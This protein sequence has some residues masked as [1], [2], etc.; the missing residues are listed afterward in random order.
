MYDTFG[1]KQICIPVMDR[2]HSLVSKYPDD[3]FY[4][5]PVDLEMFRGHLVGHI[6]VIRVPHA[7]MIKNFDAGPLAI[8]R[9]AARLRASLIRGP[10]EPDTVSWFLN[11]IL[12][13]SCGIYDPW[14]DFE[15]RDKQETFLACGETD[16]DFGQ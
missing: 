3:H 4:G 13:D 5:K 12:G 1:V 16:K 2:I 11:K 9:E 15:R 8:F 10:S 14:F 7:W 6:L